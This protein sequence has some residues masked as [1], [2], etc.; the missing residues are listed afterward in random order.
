MKDLAAV[1]KEAKTVW[2][3]DARLPN[4]PAIKDRYRRCF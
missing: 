4:T 1:T 3:D 2:G